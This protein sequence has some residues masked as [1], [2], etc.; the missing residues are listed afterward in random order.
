ME[1]DHWSNLVTSSSAEDKEE[2][3]VVEEFPNTCL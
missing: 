2:E 3:E 1:M